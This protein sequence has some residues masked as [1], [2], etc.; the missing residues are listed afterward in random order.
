MLGGG[1]GGIRRQIESSLTE[2]LD[3][4]VSHV[5]IITRQDAIEVRFESERIAIVAGDRRVTTMGNVHA[6]GGIVQIGV[7]DIRNET[8]GWNTRIRSKKEEKHF[9]YYPVTSILLNSNSSGEDK[10]VTHYFLIYLRE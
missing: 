8:I 4:G 1:G 6:V 10:A 7:L 5:P 9:I 2:A 3:P